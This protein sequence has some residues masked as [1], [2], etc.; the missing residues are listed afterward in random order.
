MNHNC[1]AIT[2]LEQM[3][4][5]FHLGLTAKESDT[6]KQTDRG[7]NVMDEGHSKEIPA[8]TLSLN[9]SHGPLPTRDQVP[10]QG[11]PM[12]GYQP[13]SLSVSKST[14]VLRESG[15]KAV[16]CTGVTQPDN[17]KHF[18]KMAQGYES[19]LFQLRDKIKDLEQNQHVPNAI[20]IIDRWFLDI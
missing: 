9:E 8:G 3:V 14:Q 4:S 6:S 5:S 18:H 11:D 7:H 10:E 17:D 16:Q 13:I 19:Q 2:L 1:E 15:D 20:L 12:A